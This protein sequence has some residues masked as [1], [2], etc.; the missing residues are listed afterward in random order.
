MGI[1]P[2][3]W[4]DQYGNNTNDSHAIVKR[5]DVFI[6]GP[7]RMICYTHT[8]CQPTFN[9]TEQN[10]VCICKQSKYTPIHAKKMCVYVC[11]NVWAEQERKRAM[12]CN[13]KR[14]PWEMN[15]M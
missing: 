6:Y 7:E 15:K 1:E 14:F 10:K 8:H 11:V 12:T 2:E 13:T 3:N 9:C 4:W 5:R